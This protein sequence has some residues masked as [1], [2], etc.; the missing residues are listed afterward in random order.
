[1]KKISLLLLSLFMF[2]IFADEL[3]AN[4]SKYQAHY[5]FK[6]D[7]GEK[8]AAAFDKYLNTPE[9]KAM[10]LEV[11]LYALEHQGWNEATHLSL[12][13]ISEPTRL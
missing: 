3:P 11:D 6:C 10:N 13:H 12:I 5:A 1:M 9:V 4:F 8:C 2:G 7:Q